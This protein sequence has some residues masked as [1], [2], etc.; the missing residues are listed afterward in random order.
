MTTLK[1]YPAYR[2]SGVPWLGEIPAHWSVSRIKN[3]F[4][5]TEERNGAGKG[6]LLSLT[7]SRGL[8]PQTEATT[9]LASAEDLSKYKICRRGQLVMNRMQA[10]SGMFAVSSHDGLVSPDYSVFRV[11]GSDKVAYFE[12]LFKT[13]LYVN[14]FARI[15]G[16]RERIQSTL[17]S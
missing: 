2:D 8:L 12:H 1:P 9:K 7:R 10:W 15:E 3:T 16:H 11:C 13:P 14:E 5:E 17:H 4:R 6:T